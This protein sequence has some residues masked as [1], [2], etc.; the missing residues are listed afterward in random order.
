MPYYTW[1]LKKYAGVSSQ[2][3]SMWYYTD[4]QG[5]LQKTTTYDEADYYLCGSAMP[6]VYGGFGTTFS[7]RGFDLSASFL[8]SIGGKAYDSG[9][10]GL[11]TSPYTDATGRNIHKDIYNAWSEENPNSNIPRWQYNDLSSAYSSDRWLTD[12]SSLTFQTLT[13]GYTVP[14]SW[15]KKMKLEKL[16]LF[17]TCDNVAYWSKRKGLDPRSSF[18]GST[19]ATGYSQTR[20]ISGGFNLS[21]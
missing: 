12:A 8:Y 3:E 18:D 15:L 7:F 17:V 5:Q 16:R 19:S 9:Y 14:K 4:D 13:L 2:G 20:T 10:A 6:D 11:M 21:F 1:R